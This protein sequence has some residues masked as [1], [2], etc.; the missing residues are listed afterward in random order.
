MKLT[1]ASTTARSRAIAP[2]RSGYSP[3]AC[4]PVSCI[5]P[6]PIRPTTRS[7]PMVMMLDMVPHSSFAG[8]DRH[9]LPQP[10]HAYLFGGAHRPAGHPLWGRCTSRRRT[11]LG[12]GP[13][14][15]RLASSRQLGQACGGGGPWR[16]DIEDDVLIGVLW[17]DQR[18][19]VQVQVAYQFVVDDLRPVGVAEHT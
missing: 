3:H 18:L 8:R 2:S 15:C 11:L 6:K 5:A 16:S 12:R 17:H 10:F 19:V 13:E 7:P 9:A 4:L 1:P 14:G